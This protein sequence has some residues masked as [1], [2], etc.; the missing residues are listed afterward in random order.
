[1]GA[2]LVPSDHRLQPRPEVLCSPAQHLHHE[3]V[4]SQLPQAAVELDGVDARKTEDVG[5][6]VGCE[7]MGEGDAGCERGHGTI[8]ARWNKTVDERLAAAAA[9]R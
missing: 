1:M 3:G 9:L 4:S 2:A 7:Q 6:A 5:N 8:L